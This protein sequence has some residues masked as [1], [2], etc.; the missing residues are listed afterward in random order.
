VDNLCDICDQRCKYIE[1]AGVKACSLQLTDVE[2]MGARRS[3]SSVPDIEKGN[4]HAYMT[5]ASV[6]FGAPH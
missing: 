6:A 4:F 3:G 1:F 5:G 2:A